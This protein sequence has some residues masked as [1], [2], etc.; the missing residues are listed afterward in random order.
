MKIRYSKP[1]KIAPFL[2]LRVRRHP[3]KQIYGTL[4]ADTGMIT[5]SPLTKSIHVRTC[6]ADT[7]AMIAMSTLKEIK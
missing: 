7:T 3:V 6:I 2:L 5:D 4:P 1:N